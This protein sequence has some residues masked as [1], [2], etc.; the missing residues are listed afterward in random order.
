MLII[1]IDLEGQFEHILLHGV[2]QDSYPD[3]GINS[4]YLMTDSKG[5]LSG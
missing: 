4:I 5:A 2:F 1:D 3:K